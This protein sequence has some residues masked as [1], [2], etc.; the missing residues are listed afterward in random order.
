LRRAHPVTYR[1]QCTAIINI[2]K[3]HSISSAEYYQKNKKQRQRG[4]RIEETANAD[5]V[6]RRAVFKIP[7]RHESPMEFHVFHGCQIYRAERLRIHSFAEMP[8]CS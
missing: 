2:Y 8:R 1:A 3:R 4:R 7:L 5:W 6:K